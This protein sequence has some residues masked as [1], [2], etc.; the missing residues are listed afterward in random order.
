MI[1]SVL[2]VWF[3]NCQQMEINLQKDKTPAK[4]G[5]L[6]LNAVSVTCCHRHRQ[7]GGHGTRTRNRLPGN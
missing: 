4:Q 6:S 1:K 5:F 3:S 2:M 7:S